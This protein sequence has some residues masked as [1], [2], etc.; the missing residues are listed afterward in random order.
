MALSF[1]LPKLIRRAKARWTHRSRK[2]KRERSSAFTGGRRS[3]SHAA[4]CWAMKSPSTEDYEKHGH[5]EV[6]A[7]EE[8]AWVGQAWVRQSCELR[9]CSF[10]SGDGPIVSPDSTAPG[11]PRCSRSCPA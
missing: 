2:V 8:R 11:P 6:G 5:R 9:S 1:H 3:A 10:C 7:Q 4:S